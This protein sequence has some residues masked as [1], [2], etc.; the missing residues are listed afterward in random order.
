MP[1]LHLYDLRSDDAL[2]P[3]TLRAA[4][5]PTT[6]VA[7]SVR[8][9][10]EEMNECNVR[11][12]ANAPSKRVKHS[13]PNGSSPR[14]TFDLAPDQKWVG[15]RRKSQLTYIDVAPD[16]TAKSSLSESSPSE[17]LAMRRESN[18]QGSTHNS[19]PIIARRAHEPRSPVFQDSQP[20]DEILPAEYRE[21]SPGLS[22]HTRYPPGPLCGLPE[23]NNDS[24]YLN[25]EEACLTR[26]FI[27]HLAPLVY[28]S[29]GI[30]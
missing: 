7:L 8:A 12:R 16:V 15:S 23:S 9:Y 19:P 10:R 14:Q 5:P 13:L 2:R 3:Y 22:S 30:S 6:T 21:S 18:R 25:F 26:H 24:S 20:E 29:G 1:S 17:P 4:L 28:I 27:E 11:K